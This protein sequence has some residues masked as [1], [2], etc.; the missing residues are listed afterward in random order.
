[1][2]DLDEAIARET[3]A[4]QDPDAEVRTWAERAAYQDQQAAG[5][6]TLDELGAK[7]R[8]LDEDRATAERELDRLKGGQQRLRQLKAQK[9]F[10]LETFG[11]GMKLRLMWFPP[12]MRRA[13][14]QMLRLKITVSGDG[15]IWAEADVDA[16]V[17]RLTRDVEEYARRLNEAK[18][19]IEDQQ[20]SGELST[21]EAVQ[22]IEGDLRR[23]RDSFSTTET[24][25]AM[26][27][28][29]GEELRG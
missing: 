23:V 6:M 15:T 13:I 27:V 5:Y 9:R 26:S 2:N 29:A 8:Q 24:D 12:P 25:I 14:Y 10:V 18:G 28:V 17:I 22:L 1:V 16:N 3:A 4:L 7:L 11:E 20:E 19:R 21:W